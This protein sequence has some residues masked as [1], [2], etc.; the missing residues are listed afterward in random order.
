MKRFGLFI[1]AILAFGLGGAARGSADGLIVNGSFEKPS[2][3]AG[4][5][6]MVPN[7]T[8]G[9]GWATTDSAGDMEIDT[10]GAIGGSSA[11]EGKQSLEVNAYN[12][13]DVYQTITGLTVGK[14]YL[15]SWAYGDRPGSG[16]EELQ[17]FFTP[18]TDLTD[19]IPVATDFDNLDGS[20]PT[21][22]WF[23]NSV[24]VTATST[25]EVL[26]FNGVY[27]SGVTNNGGISY[28]NEIDAV[29]LMATPEPSTLLFFVSGLGLLSLAWL[30]QRPLPVFSRL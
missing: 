4:G 25:T 16:D 20:N 5:W 9:F 19:A 27:D 7:G 30:R 8:P 13:E 14:T 1:V 3:S 28:G 10:P 22:L 26:S 11:Y 2:L 6:T 24:V 17:V 12:P 18:T 15:L 29:S 23:P 21:L